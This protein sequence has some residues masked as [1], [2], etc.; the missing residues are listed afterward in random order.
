MNF[1]AA[2]IQVYGILDAI[3][4]EM[5][6][7][8]GMVFLPIQFRHDGF[9]GMKKN[10]QSMQYSV[11]VDCQKLFFCRFRCYNDFSR[12]GRCL[13]ISANDAFSIDEEV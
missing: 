7:P 10:Y 9:P 12:A 2:E 5:S 13:K 4:R 11:I 6:R 8:G 1:I 3:A